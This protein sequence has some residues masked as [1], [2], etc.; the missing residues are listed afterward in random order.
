MTDTSQLSCNYLTQE[1]KTLAGLPES[2]TW[3]LDQARVQKHR[4]TVTFKT[5]HFLELFM[6]Q[7]DAK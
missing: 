5:L 6:P 7:T 2:P 3:F 1:D 4:F